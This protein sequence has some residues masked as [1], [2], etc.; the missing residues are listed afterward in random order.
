M[1]IFLLAAVAL[2]LTAAAVVV[3]GSA[4]Q[5]SEAA[6][7][8]LRRGVPTAELHVAMARPA[9]PVVT[10]LAKVSRWIT[11]RS[12][13]SSLDERLTAADLQR[14]WSED[15]V[16]AAKLVLGSIGTLLGLLRISSGPSPTSVLMAGILA[17]GCWYLPDFLASQRA[18]ARRGRIARELPDTMDQLTISVEAGLGFE[19]A[20]ARVARQG[21]G[22]LAAELRRT[23]QDIQ[24]GMDRGAALDALGERC[25][26]AELK[27]FVS[28]T[29]QAERYGLPIAAVLRTQ[30]LELRDRRRQQAEERAMKLPVKVLFPL[31]FCIMPTLFI[32]IL[33][34]GVI[35]VV[36]AG[37][38]G[39]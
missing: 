2:L 36:R 7:N 22:P 31:M 35:N 39:G 34:P 10:S 18:D 27:R 15:H 6:A 17:F 28:A 30:A 19:S 37:G 26:V 11:P 33:A 29:R 4:A 24:L 5:T 9:S 8:A 25:G 16:L 23:L 32:V 1:P 20:L 13:T 21:A 14:E 38:L 12:L 3:R